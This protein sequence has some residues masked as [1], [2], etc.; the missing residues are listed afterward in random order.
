MWKTYDEWKALEFQVIK[1]SVASMIDGELKFNESQVIDLQAQ[2][3]ADREMDPY[4]GDY[5]E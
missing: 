2:A 1:G 4:L 5:L 3:E